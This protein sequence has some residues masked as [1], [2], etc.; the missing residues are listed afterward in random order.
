MPRKTTTPKRLSNEI[1]PA[2]RTYLESGHRERGDA[3]L[4]L[5]AGNRERL[6]RVWEELRRVILPAFIKANPCRRPWCWWE[7]DAP[8]QDTGSGA[9]FEPLPVPRRR[10]G[11][12]G[13]M[14]VEVFPSIV[15]T[16]DRGIPSFA[17]IDPADPPQFEAESV[18]LGRCGLLTPSEVRYLAQHPEVRAPEVV[19]LEDDADAPAPRAEENGRA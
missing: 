2:L 7:I 1:P 11:G 13:R 4:F 8:R 3:G 19:T 5:L 16:F 14:T 15:P 17:E 12:K 9:Y 10:V 18:F 6:R